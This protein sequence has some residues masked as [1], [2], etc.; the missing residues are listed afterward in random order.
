MDEKIMMV[1]ARPQDSP[2]FD[3]TRWFTNGMYKPRSAPLQ[4]RETHHSII[5]V[6]TVF[7]R[8]IFRMSK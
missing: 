5:G 2:L 7:A 6:W 3:A 4:V 1:P 8:L